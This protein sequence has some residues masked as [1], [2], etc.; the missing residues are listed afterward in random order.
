MSKTFFFYCF[1]VKINLKV[2]K[3]MKEAIE[4]ARKTMNLNYGGPFGAMIMKDNKIKDFF[5]DGLK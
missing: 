5:A 2:V 1:N 4:E 3:N